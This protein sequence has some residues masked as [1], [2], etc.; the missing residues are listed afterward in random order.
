MSKPVVKG[1][2]KGVVPRGKR[3]YITHLPP[4]PVEGSK[5]PEKVREE[6]DIIGG[7]A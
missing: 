6:P 2:P 5:A 7:W 1:R 4:I 3:P